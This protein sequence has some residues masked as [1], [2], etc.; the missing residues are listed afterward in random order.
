MHPRMPMLACTHHVSWLKPAEGG[1]FLCSY[2]KDFVTRKDIWP[3]FE[4]LG[5]DFQR[6]WE[7]HEKGQPMET[8]NTAPTPPT[9]GLTEN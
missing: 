1:K 6:R 4:E 5:E 7:A 9:G 3:K 8:L 2:C